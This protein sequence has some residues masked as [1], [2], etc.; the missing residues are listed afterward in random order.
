MRSVVA[1]H[2]Q[3]ARIDLE[4][5][6]DENPSA[7]AVKIRRAHHS[8]GRG[9]CR[10]PRVGR[11]VVEVEVDISLRIAVVGEST[12]CPLRGQKTGVRY[13]YLRYYDTAA[14]R[15]SSNVRS[16]SSAG[17]IPRGVLNSAYGP[18]PFGL[19]LSPEASDRRS[20]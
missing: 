11:V 17:E 18:D 19:T 1:G 4:V 13:D 12:V 20:L 5:R 2:V 14:S 10:R 7:P 8:G 16:V 15:Y 6:A 9:S 3:I